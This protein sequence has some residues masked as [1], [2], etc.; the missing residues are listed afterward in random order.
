MTEDIIMVAAQP[1]LIEGGIHID[2]RGILSF[3]NGFDFAGVQRS[4]IVRSHRAGQ[5]RGWVGHK[6]E[7]KWFWAIQGTCKIAVVKP[8]E[9][10][11]PASNLSVETFILSDRKPAVLHIPAGY[12]NAIMSL[13]EDAILMVFSTGKIADASNDDYRFALDTWP[14]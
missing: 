4:Y 11:L 12:A 9:W 3:V 1:R 5:K 7:Q 6:I 14:I 13:S 2:E 10:E 8:D